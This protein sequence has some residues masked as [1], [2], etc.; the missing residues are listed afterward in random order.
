MA[1]P[2]WALGSPS[3]NKTRLI[4]A[5]KQRALWDTSQSHTRQVLLHPLVQVGTLRLWPICPRATQGSG[6][7]MLCVVGTRYYLGESG[8]CVHLRGEAGHQLTPLARMLG[9]FKW[10]SKQ[11]A[12]DGHE[13]LLLLLLLLLLKAAAGEE[14]ADGGVPLPLNPFPSLLSASG[15]GDRWPLGAGCSIPP[16]RGPRMRTGAGL[17]ATASD[18]S[19]SGP[20]PPPGARCRATAARRAPIGRRRAGV[21]GSAWSVGQRG[22][23]PGSGRGSMPPPI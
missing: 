14:V 12:L 10:S 3:E 7:T 5:A 17:I 22:R 23:G 8:P 19:L 9:D 2:F 21:P 1:F 6:D 4:S 13:L 20:A 15:R 18:P 11:K 16:G